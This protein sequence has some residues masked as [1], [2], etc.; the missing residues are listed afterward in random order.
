MIVSC[1]RVDVISRVL[2]WQN[3]VEKYV[4][5]AVNHTNVPSSKT[6][7]VALSSVLL[8]AVQ[9]SCF[10]ACSFKSSP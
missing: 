1:V 10:S 7:Q 4:K 8:L 5:V 3:F 6:K 9:M 2:Y